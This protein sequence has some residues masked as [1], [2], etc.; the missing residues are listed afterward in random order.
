MASSPSP[1]SSTRIKVLTRYKNLVARSQSSNIHEAAL[2][3]ECAADLVRKHGITQ[4][5]ITQ[6]YQE[7]GSRRYAGA[8]YH[9][10]WQTSLAVS[11]A[12]R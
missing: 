1:S 2:A 5:E 7:K 12:G 4:D 10:G 8:E 6:L 11:V 9:A 3:K